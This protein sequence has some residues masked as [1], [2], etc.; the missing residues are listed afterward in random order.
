V[1]YEAPGNNVPRKVKFP[2]IFA[3]S[4]RCLLDDLVGAHEERLRQSE[5]ELLG[6]LQIEDQLEPGRLLD[7]QVGRLGALENLSGVNARLAIGIRE[8]RPI[9]DQAAR[10]DEFASLMI[11]SRGVV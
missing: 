11:V 4:A 2:V 6:G 8:A 7:R 3:A 9:A 5:A 1:W 10:R